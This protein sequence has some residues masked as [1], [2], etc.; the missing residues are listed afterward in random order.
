M[1]GG[2]EFAVG[3][4]SCVGLMMKAAVGERATQT[5]VKE[6]EQKRD[7]NAFAGEPVSVTAAIPLEQAMALSLR[8][9]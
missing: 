4:M 9:S 1:I 7:L 3:P 6:E 2:L 8:R 5:L